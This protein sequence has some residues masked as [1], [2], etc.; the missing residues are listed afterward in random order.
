MR[1]KVVVT[2]SAMMIA[3]KL[4][5]PLLAADPST[6]QLGEIAALLESNDVQGLRDYLET[7]PDLAAGDTT[8]ARLLREFLDESANVSAFLGFK[9]DLSE[10]VQGAE[11]ESPQAETQT[12]VEP[13]Y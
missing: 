10:S 7:Y 9:P 3:A 5:S 6:E 2:V 12:P 1:R 11:V 4:G 8:L 13:A